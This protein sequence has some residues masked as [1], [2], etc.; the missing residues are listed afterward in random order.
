[1]GVGGRD[2]VATIRWV[3]SDLLPESPSAAAEATDWMTYFK[4]GRKSLQ[5]RPEGTSKIQYFKST[6]AANVVLRSV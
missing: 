4:A 5:R 2:S 3:I 6:N 1:M